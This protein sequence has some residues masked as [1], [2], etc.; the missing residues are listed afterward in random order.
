[1]KFL[2]LLLVHIPD[3][4]FSLALLI[5]M[6]YL[7]YRGAI[8]SWENPPDVKYIVAVLLIGVGLGI[9][10]VLTLNV[11]ESKRKDKVED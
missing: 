10:R 9:L 8:A 5:G 3:Q 6:I 2:R 1:M 4:V 7:M 11:D